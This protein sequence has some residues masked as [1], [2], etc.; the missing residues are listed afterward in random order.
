MNDFNNYISIACALLGV[1]I[2]VLNLLGFVTAANVVSLIVA[3]LM[4]I[5]MVIYFDHFNKENYGK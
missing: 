5:G 3:V 2:S 1:L 4:C